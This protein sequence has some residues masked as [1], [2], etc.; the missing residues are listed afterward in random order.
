M[1]LRVKGYMSLKIIHAIHWVE[2][3]IDFN[4]KIKTVRFF[5]RTVM[6]VKKN[7]RFYKICYDNKAKKYVFIWMVMTVNFFFFFKNGYWNNNSFDKVISTLCSWTNKCYTALQ[8]LILHCKRCYLPTF[9]APDSRNVVRNIGASRL[10][11]IYNHQ[12]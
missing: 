4:R 11:N 6:T 7:I 2:D 9:P 8:R 1:R 12:T 10:K 3:K 5:I